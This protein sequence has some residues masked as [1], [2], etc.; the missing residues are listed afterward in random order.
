M[1]DWQD[2]STAPKD[3]TPIF[4]WWDGDF[5]P[6]A[7]WQNGAWVYRMAQSWEP[8]TFGAEVE[9]RLLCYEPT[10]WAPLLE[11]EARC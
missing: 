11:E 2:I 5:A 9:A 1:S 4:L 7:Q 6:I 10:H 3:G 8:P